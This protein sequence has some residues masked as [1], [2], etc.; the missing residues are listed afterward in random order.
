MKLRLS[1][2]TARKEGWA[3]LVVLSLSATALLLMASVVSWSNENSAVVAR[4]NE[5]FA[6]AYAAEAAT[7]KVL[8]QVVQDYQDYGEGLVFTKTASYSSMLPTATD[9]SYWTNYQF[10]GGT[11]N[12]SV[13]VTRAISNSSTILGTPYSGLVAVGA[14]Y[15]I[16]ANAQNLHSQ[17]GI[18]ST[19]GQKLILSQIPIFQFA[20]FY[21][22][23]M[24]LDPGAN[25]NVTGL[26]HGN[27]NINIGPNTGATLTFSN[28]VSATGTIIFGSNVFN[29]S[30]SGKGATNFIVAPT[31]GALSLN[32]PVGTNIS[33]TNASGVDAILQVPP[34]GEAA[35]SSIGTNRLFNQADLIVLISNGNQITV[36]SGVGI[37]NQA[38]VIS[39]SQWSLFLSTNGTFYNGREGLNVNPVN[40]NVGALRQWSATNTVLRPVLAA[41]PSRS[42]A[43]ADVQSVFLADM[44][45]GLSNVEPGIVLTNGAALPSNGL[46]VV[47]P[48][49]IYVAGN[50]NVTT[51]V[52]SSGVPINLTTD[53]YVVSNTLPSAIYTDAIT[54]LSPNWSPLNS[55]NSIGNRIATDDT[56]NAAILTGNVPSTTGSY[57]GG[58]ENFQRLLENWSGVNLYC[59]GSMVEMF[60]S[61]IGKAAWPGTG[62]V[63][64]PPARDWAF[65]TNFLNPAQLPPLTPKVLY[66]QRV[67]WSTLPPY[68]TQF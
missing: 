7:E 46:S 3:L 23:F 64:N 62:V 35:S 5:T 55:S 47:S 25:M 53:S 66:I 58:V 18:V 20:I 36:T 29:S 13:I 59:N 19:V 52:N 2:F 17:Y 41:A 65:D 21:N 40:L 4:N 32:L 43:T 34:A 54:I 27:T 11:T 9:N 67:N 30:S 1:N 33:G 37:N 28:N 16:I 14:T 49:P 38:T 44:R 26:V 57:S 60:T 51:N 24:E 15:E 12:N 8:A 61:Q 68:T 48:D 63:Y 42:S 50:W 10:S 22:D 45:T 6:T 39:N 56:V 31:T